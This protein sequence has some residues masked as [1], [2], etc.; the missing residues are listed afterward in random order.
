MKLPHRR[1][2]LHM[3]AGA[4]ALP[5]VLPPS[6]A[7]AAA[8]Y[9]QTWTEIDVGHLVLAKEDGPAQSWWEAIP[10]EKAADD[11]FTLR[12]RDHAQLSTIVRPRLRLALLH[13]AP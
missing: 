10:I 12:W 1:Q 9:P 6:S 7:P 5:A 3:A 4:A 13:P 11:A 2:F 8:S